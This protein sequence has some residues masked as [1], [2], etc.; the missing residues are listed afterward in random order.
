MGARL[1]QAG[2]LPVGPKVENLELS[3][4]WDRSRD[5]MG[6][7]SR[8]DTPRDTPPGPARASRCKVVRLHRLLVTREGLFRRKEITRFMFPRALL[9]YRPPTLC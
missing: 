9:L 8:G 4:L 3:G 7:G 5:A 2:R 6:A 1:H